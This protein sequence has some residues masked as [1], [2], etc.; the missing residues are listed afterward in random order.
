MTIVYTNV[1]RYKG[2]KA[3]DVSMKIEMKLGN[4]KDFI[5]TYVAKGAR[6]FLKSKDVTARLYKKNKFNIY[7]GLRIV[8]KAEII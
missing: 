6:E 4:T 8:G 7:A 2:C 5:E 3:V 1:G